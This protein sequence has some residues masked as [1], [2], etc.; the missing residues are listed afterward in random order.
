MQ[1][2][3][4]ISTIFRRPKPANSDL[5]AVCDFYDSAKTFFTTSNLSKII[6]FSY[7]FYSSLEAES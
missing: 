2:G 1:T 6:S 7:H 4:R 3:R 5:F